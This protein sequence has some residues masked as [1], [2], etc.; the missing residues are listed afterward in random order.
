N[1][2]AELPALCEGLAE[3]Q[4]TGC[5]RWK[6]VWTI[7]RQ[8]AGTVNHIPRQVHLRRQPHL[9]TGGDV[10]PLIMIKIAIRVGAVGSVIGVSRAVQQP[11]QRLS[12]ILGG[13]VRKRRVETQPPSNQRR[14]NAGL[15]TPNTGV[16]GG[17]GKQDI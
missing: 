8:N 16:W 15:K 12:S 17:Q 9:K 7:R 4:V 1:R 3:V 6:V 2:D 11:S 14:A 13:L 10:D 5:V